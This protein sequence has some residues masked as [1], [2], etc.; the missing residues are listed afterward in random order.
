MT[1]EMTP[2]RLGDTKHAAQGEDARQGTGDKATT[3]AERDC[4]WACDTD[5]SIPSSYGD[6][7]DMRLMYFHAKAIS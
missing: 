2:L 7:P 1:R 5:S 3:H 6:S 4:F